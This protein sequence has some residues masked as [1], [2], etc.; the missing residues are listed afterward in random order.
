MRLVKKSFSKVM[1]IWDEYTS[2]DNCK[3]ASFYGLKWC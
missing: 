2:Y 3:G 1:E